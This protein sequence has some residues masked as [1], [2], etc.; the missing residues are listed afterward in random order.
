MSPSCPS[1]GER[2]QKPGGAG[3]RGQRT[4]AATSPAGRAAR[5]GRLPSARP[6][7]AGGQLTVFAV[8]PHCQLPSGRGETAQAVSCPGVEATKEEERR[9]EAGWQ[10]GKETRALPSDVDGEPLREQRPV[11]WG[12]SGP[13]LRQV[14]GRERTKLQPRAG[15]GPGAPQG[16]GGPRL[17]RP[18]PCP[19]RAPPA[20]APSSAS[21]RASSFLGKRFFRRDA[22]RRER[23]CGGGDR[24]GGETGAREEAGGGAGRGAGAPPSRL[25][26][27]GTDCHPAAISLCHGSGLLATAAGPAAPSRSPRRRRRRGL[28]STRRCPARS[29]HTKRRGADQQAG[30]D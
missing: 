3:A 22:R 7:F 21:P 14:V 19:L 8:R 16:R 1:P 29:S 24:R 9:G 2:P 23:K 4:A 28:N 27:P 25:A 17:R 13:R 6:D 30:P 26:G 10:G 11:L 5:R 12:P 15:G 18:A 20:R